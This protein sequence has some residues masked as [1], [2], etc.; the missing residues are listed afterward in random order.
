[1]DAGFD[2]IQ[3]AKFWDDEVEVKEDSFDIEKELKRIKN[4]KTKLGDI[5][6]LGNHKLICGDSTNLNTIK[7]LLGKEKVSMIYSDPVYNIKIDYDGG[8]GGNKDYGGN[9][10]DS[11]TFEEYKLFIKDSL[12]SALSVS[13]PDAHVFYWCDQIYIGLIQDI[14]RLLGISNRRVCL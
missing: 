10:N 13:N 5:I 14:Y 11:R 1:M 6:K 8:I 4:P 3:L 7:K 12:S 9:V 2:Q